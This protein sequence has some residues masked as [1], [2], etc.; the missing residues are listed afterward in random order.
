[1][2]EYYNQDNNRN[3]NPSTQQNPSQFN[4]NNPPTNNV[5]MYYNN[6]NNTQN[7]NQNLNNNNYDGMGYNYDNSNNQNKYANPTYPV[8]QNVQYLNPE[9]ESH[10]LENAEFISQNCKYIMIGT[11][12]CCFVVFLLLLLVRK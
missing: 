2:A 11:S 8:V 12:I 6:D 1:M 5:N 10:G 3:N 4:Q 9:N 7:L